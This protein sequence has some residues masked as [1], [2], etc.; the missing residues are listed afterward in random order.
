MD[1][2][3]AALQVALTWQMELVFT[4]EM[5]RPPM[6]FFFWRCPS[7]TPFTRILSYAPECFLQVVQH[8]ILRCSLRMAWESGSLDPITG[9][10]AGYL[11]G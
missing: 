6:H 10:A 8:L 2:M 5:C 1:G 4:L 7:V 3:G 11:D 9:V